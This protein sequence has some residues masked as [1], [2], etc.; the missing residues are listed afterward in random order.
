MTP[1]RTRQVERLRELLAAATPDPEWPRRSIA[2]M[3]TCDGCAETK[4]LIAAYDDPDGDNEPWLCRT[5]ADWTDLQVGAITTLPDLLATAEAHA[6]LVKAVVSLADEWEST[7][8][9]LPPGY[10]MTVNEFC[11]EWFKAPLRA[12]LT[13]TD[14]AA[15]RGAR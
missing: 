13:A 5:C 12:I 6:A 10:P 15:D 7:V 8:Y 9:K 4:P 2:H 11:R 1:D 3:G 14:T